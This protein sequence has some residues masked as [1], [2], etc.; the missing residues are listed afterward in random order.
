MPSHPEP[1]CL[2]LLLVCERLQAGAEKLNLAAE[3]ARPSAVKGPLIASGHCRGPIVGTERAAA[4]AACCRLPSRRCHRYRATLDSEL[5]LSK[6]KSCRRL[7]QV[8]YRCQPEW[9]DC[10][11]RRLANA[12]QP[13]FLTVFVVLIEFYSN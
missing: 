1:S 8:K 9:V 7:Q 3:A 2:F 6:L 4:A 13:C 5:A 12:C 11:R 10:A